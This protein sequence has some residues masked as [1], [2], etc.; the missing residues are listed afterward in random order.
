LV[1]LRPD[2]IYRCPKQAA[3]ILR[4][5]GIMKFNAKKVIRLTNKNPPACK[6]PLP[7]TLIFD[8]QFEKYQ[9]NEKNLITFHH[10]TFCF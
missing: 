4:I 10:G 5:A 6:Q 1:V 9:L 8:Q 3:K 7:G 2:S